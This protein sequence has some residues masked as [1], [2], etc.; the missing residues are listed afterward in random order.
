MTL[1]WPSACGP[2]LGWFGLA[3]FGPP[4]LGGDAH[5]DVV[6]ESAARPVVLSAAPFQYEAQF[7]V[8]SPGAGVVLEEVEFDLVVPENR[9]RIIEE[10]RARLRTVSPVEVRPVS[11][12]DAEHRRATRQI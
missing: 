6:P 8:H 7:L 4:F 5:E 1:P 12:D 3:V 9:E 11:D 2:E 10:Q